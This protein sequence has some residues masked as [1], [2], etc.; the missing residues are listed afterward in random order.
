M[1]GNS[2][3]GILKA[4]DAL[5]FAAARRCV[6]DTVGR[7]E[8]IVEPVSLAGA[9]GR[10]LAVDISAD[11]DYPPVDRSIRDGF[12][13]RAADIPG[14]LQ[15]AGEVRAGQ[16]YCG[17]VEAGQ[18]VRIMTG[19]PIP[20]GADAVIMVEHATVENGLMA[21]TRAAQ[22]GEFINR[23]GCETHKGDTVLRR[24]TRL[25]F[26]HIAMLATVGAAEVAVFRRPRV[27]I[28]ATGDE[29]VPV[30]AV[31][32]SFEVR[33]SN[34]W[35][36]AAQ[37]AGAGGIPTVLPVAPDNLEATIALVEE[38]LQ[39]DLLLLSGGVSAGDYDFVEA[40]LAHCGAEFFFTRVKIRPGAPLVFGRARGRFFFGLPGNPL[41]TA[42][43]FTVFAR[44]ALELLSGVSEPVLPIAEAHITRTL[45]E[46]TGLTRFL[47]AVLENGVA[48]V[49]PIEWKGSSDVPSLARS[50]A[51]I[52]AAADREI[53]EE[54]SVVPVLLQ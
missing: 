52:V 34:S 20:A 14:S 4:V 38:G 28:L 22:A 7:P 30:E 51:F 39:A 49:T 37:V 45:R 31:P 42:V 44:A 24:G 5:D 33:N 36:L 32:R 2:P 17:I 16:D 41:S 43:T 53:Y 48:R 15:I 18:C 54:G 10:V 35:A 25:G 6:L 50:N 47:P 23:A 9:A 11:R 26:A 40:A 12:A 13:V 29:I 3:A 21:T 19:A 1:V 8:P 46:K 27:A